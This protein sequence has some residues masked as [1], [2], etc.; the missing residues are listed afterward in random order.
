VTPQDAPRKRPYQGFFVF[1]RFPSTLLSCLNHPRVATKRSRVSMAVAAA[2]TGLGT[3]GAIA[4]TVPQAASASTLVGSVPVAAVAG[5]LSAPGIH[6]DAEDANA[7]PGTPEPAVAQPAPAQH[8]TAKP[9]AAKTATVQSTASAPASQSETTRIVAVGTVQAAS[10][11]SASAPAGHAANTPAKATPQAAP[12][13][14]AAPAGSAA[15]ATKATPA[16]PDAAAVRRVAGAGHAVVS[17]AARPA[18]KPAAPAKPYLI[19]DSV[20]P[21]A[22]PAHEQIATY[23]NGHY[24]A[25]Q[26]SVRGRGNVLWIDTNGSDPSASALDVEPGDATPSGASEWVKEKLSAQPNGV[27]IV[28]TMRSEWQGV[29]DAIGSLPASMQS[30]VRYWIADPTGVNHNVAG[31][32]ATQWYW[33]NNYDISTANPGF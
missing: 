3:F 20:S 8:A 28:Y 25:S 4:G 7:R 32:S 19:Y 29:K 31:A 9:A 15:T 14:T 23:A 18:P 13:R 12:A 10:T 11:P 24:Q 16:R 22:I 17:H 2:V 27:A 26:S 30:K 1:S 33:G 5:T 6:T 21:T